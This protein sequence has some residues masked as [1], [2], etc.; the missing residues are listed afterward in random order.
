MLKNGEGNQIQDNYERSSKR[1]FSYIVYSKIG[2][3]GKFSLP[4]S[5]AVFESDGKIQETH[6][7]I[8]HFMSDQVKR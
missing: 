8:V 7:N 4:E 6:S 1:T 3:I 2:V 5:K